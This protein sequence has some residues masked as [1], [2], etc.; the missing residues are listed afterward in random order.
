MEKYNDATKWIIGRSFCYADDPLER[1]NVYFS[2]H[3]KKDTT[4]AAFI[5]L[6]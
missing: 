6:A 4:A 1:F 5:T 2:V 3:M